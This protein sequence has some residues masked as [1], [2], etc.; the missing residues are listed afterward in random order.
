MRNG[1]KDSRL[2]SSFKSSS[3]SLVFPSSRPASH[4]PQ[5][6]QKNRQRDRNAKAR[7]QRRFVHGVNRVVEGLMNKAVNRIGQPKEKSPQAAREG[8]V[9]AGFFDFSVHGN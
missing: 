4:D 7:A 9:Q 3:I 2:R 5:T 8:Q 6:E 1:T